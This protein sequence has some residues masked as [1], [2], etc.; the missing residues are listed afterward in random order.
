MTSMGKRV[1][2]PPA[3]SPVIAV[4]DYRRSAATEGPLRQVARKLDP[5]EAGVAAQ[6]AP[7]GAEEVDDRIALTLKVSAETYKRLRRHAYLVD[8][9]HQAILEQALIEF[10][11]RQE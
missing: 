6:A 10:L 7:R 8:R 11:D 9:K 4:P 2:Q 5:G 1:L 3:P